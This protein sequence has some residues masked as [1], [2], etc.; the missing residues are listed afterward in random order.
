M[1]KLQDFKR[2]RCTGLGTVTKLVPGGVICVCFLKYADP[3]FT[4]TVDRHLLK[5]L[6]SQM[7]WMRITWNM[8]GAGKRT[9]QISPKWEFPRMQVM[10]CLEWGLPHSPLYKCNPNVEMKHTPLGAMVEK[11]LD[12]DVQYLVVAPS[13]TKLCFIID[14][15]LPVLQNWVLTKGRGQGCCFIDSIC[16][17]GSLHW[18]K[19]KGSDKKS[20]ET[21]K[22]VAQVKVN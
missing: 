18:E 14:L 4:I 6:F 21:K 19:H 13:V 3:S 17:D 8:G 5:H 12:L 1:E 7:L 11:S 9:Y 10:K 2:G 22:I 15:V 20:K 16:H